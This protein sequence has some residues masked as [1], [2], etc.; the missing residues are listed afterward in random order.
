M[1]GHDDLLA[2]DGDEGAGGVGFV[3]DPGDDVHVLIG[4]FL[5]SLSM[6][7]AAGDEAAV[8]VHLVDDEGASGLA[9]D[10][11]AALEAFEHHVVDFGVE[12][13]ERRL[14]VRGLEGSGGG[15]GGGGRNVCRSHLSLLC[16]KERGG[17]AEERDRPCGDGCEPGEGVS[18]GDYHT[19]VLVGVSILMERTYIRSVGV[20]TMRTFISIETRWEIRWRNSI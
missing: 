4:E 18:H 20:V 11:D 14:L 7:R 19:A 8:G 2:G 17:Q 6:A 13:D 12:A 15:T 9:G 3:V 16:V 5:V 1:A 10:V